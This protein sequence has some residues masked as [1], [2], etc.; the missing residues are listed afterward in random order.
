MLDTY[1]TKVFDSAAG[2]MINPCLKNFLIVQSRD[3]QLK[4][5]HSGTSLTP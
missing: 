3:Q 4:G 1:G 5:T 2:I